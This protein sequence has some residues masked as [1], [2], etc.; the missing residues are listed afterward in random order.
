MPPSVPRKRLRDESPNPSKS[1][2]R[3][4]AKTAAAPPPS[5]PGRKRKATLYDDLDASAASVAKSSKTFLESLDDSED[6]S[7]L[8]DLSDGDFEDVPI[9]KRHVT[10]GSGD[11]DED[12]D[13]DDIEFEDVPAPRTSMLDTSVG[14]GLQKGAGLRAGDV[15]TG[16]GLRQVVVRGLCLH[17]VVVCEHGFGMRN[18]ASA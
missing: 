13:D 12:E 9:A 15:W 17:V 16:L 10:V 1:K 3:Q 14:T 7:S 4:V 6:G 11:D 5:S 8:S 2:R 18:V